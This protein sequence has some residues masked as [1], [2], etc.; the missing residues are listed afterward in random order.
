MK[1]AA[2]IWLGTS[3]QLQELKHPLVLIRGFGFLP[4][5]ALYNHVAA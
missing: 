3:R 4:Y 5:S 2:L 1:M